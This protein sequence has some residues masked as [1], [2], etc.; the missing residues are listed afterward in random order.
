M[1]ALIT[2]TSLLV[3]GQQTTVASWHEIDSLFRTI[4]KN[5]EPGV[6]IVI[7]EKGK[8]FF[9]N[10]YGIADMAT[11]HKISSSTNFNIG[12]LTKQFTAMSILQLAEKKKLSLDDKLGKF[13][14]EVN[15]K[16]ADAI[17]VRHLLTHSSGIVEHYDLTDC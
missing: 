16:L 13:F 2:F 15:R 9:K 17:T 10:N 3:Q 14:P 7:M 12:S 8:P 4:Y 11:R 1:I 6:S 5:D